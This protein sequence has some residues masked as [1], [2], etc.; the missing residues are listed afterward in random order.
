MPLIRCKKFNAVLSAV[1]ND[2]A[3]PETIA[4][5]SPYFT[6]ELSLIFISNFIF[7]STVLKTVFAISNPAIIPSAFTRNFPTAFLDFEIVALVVMSPF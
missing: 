1:S 2:C 6:L 3:F 4:A 7:G 5:T